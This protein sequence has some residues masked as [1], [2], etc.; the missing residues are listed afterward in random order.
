MNNLKLQEYFETESLE[1]LHELKLVSDKQYYEGENCDLEDFQ[2]DMLKETL[3][4]RD[5][6]YVPPV[7][8]KIREGENRV[9]LPFWLGS[10]DK[11]RPE[12]TRDLERWLSREKSEEYIIEDKLDGVSC[13]LV[14]KNKKLKLYTRG[15]GVIGADISYLAQYFKS[16]PE[17]VA[18]DIA[19]RGELIMKKAVFAEKY[20]KIYANARNMVA[21]RLGGKKIREGLSDIDF[22]AYEIVELDICLDPYSQIQYLQYLGFK[23]VN[24]DVVTSITPDSLSAIFIDFKERSEYDIDGVIVQPNDYRERN[25][26]GNPAY[27]FAFKMRMEENSAVVEVLDVEWSISKWGV[28][29]PRVSISPVS[30][31]GVTISYSSGFNGKYIY[32]NNIGPGAV[33]RIT[34]SG[35]V[36]P[37][38][39]DV[40]SQAKEPA[41]PDISYFWNETGVDISTEE[42]GD[43]PE[44][45]RISSFFSGLGIKH[46]SEATVNKM[47]S[48]GLVTLVRILS[49]SKDDLAVIEGFGERLAERTYENIHNGLRNVELSLVLGASGV[50]GFGFGIK[51]IKSLLGSIPDILS[52]Y[53]NY[54]TD[55]M[56]E[57]VMAVEGYSSKSAKKIVDNLDRADDF[58]ESLSPYVTF[59]SSDLSSSGIFDSMKFCLSGFRDAE[60]EKKIVKRG[61]KMVTSVSK[62]TSVVIV[63]VLDS[64]PS[65][66]VKKALDLGKEVMT[67][68]SFEERYF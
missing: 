49:A 22:V 13:L 43:V 68:E 19:V 52:I 47:Y 14:V 56:F 45:K 41:M 37:Y 50:F 60:L 10:M 27:A 54:T 46:V 12:D 58:I 17:N 15:D 29:K 53:K 55:E 24:Q 7:G 21:G 61:G 16:L 63:K 34:R 38:I 67:K 11:L 25:T 35:D 18:G 44:V 57:K 6:D 9:R 2:Y 1:T 5:P 40:I 20:S 33:V 26:S 23:T 42:H 64:N 66:K 31:G 65:G 30:L 4:R 59:K 39:T 51:K 32:S 3:Q 48:H 8:S 36:I 28:L 62:N